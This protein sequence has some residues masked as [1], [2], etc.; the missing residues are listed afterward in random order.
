MNRSLLVKTYYLLFISLLIVGILLPSFSGYSQLSFTNVAAAKNLQISSVNKD[1]GFTF[2]DFNND[3]Y[4]DLLI[5]TNSTTS[6]SRLLYNNGAPNFTFTDV[7]SL[8]APALLLNINERSAIAGD[9]DNDGDIDFVRNTHSLIEVYKNSGAPNYTFTKSQF[10]NAAYFTG[11]GTQSGINSEGMGF[12]DFDGDGDLD[13]LIEDHEY[14]VDI[15]INNGTGIFSHYTT[16][17]APRGFGTTGTSGDYSLVADLNNDG[18]ID[19]LARREGSGNNNAQADIFMNNGN[20]TFS[21]NITTNLNASNSN[22]GGVAAGDF[23]GDGDLDYFWTDNGSTGS[24]NNCFLVEQTGVNSGVFAVTTVTV[25]GS[26]TSLPSAG[27]IDGVTIG[28]VNHDGKIDLFLTAN[29]GTS[30]LLI[31]TSA[32][33]GLFSFNHNNYGI[34][35]NADGEGCEFVDFD[36][37]GDL[38]L[39]INVNNG[40]NQLWINALN[41]NKYVNVIPLIDIGGGLTRPA[42]GATVILRNCLGE[43]ISPIMEVNGGSGHGTQLSTI[44]HFGLPAGAQTVYYAEVSFVRPNG[45]SRTVVTKQIYLG[46]LPD[47][48]IN[49]VNTDAS[50]PNM[51]YVLS[52]PGLIDFSAVKKGE[53]TKIQWQVNDNA[54]IEKYEVEYNRQSENFI[55]VHS[56]PDNNSEN[57]SFEHFIKNEGTLYYRLKIIHTDKSISYSKIVIINSGENNTDIQKTYPN[58]FSSYITTDIQLEQADKIFVQLID[59][60]GNTIKN[61]IVQ[62]QPGL[63]RV[64]LNELHKL[65]NG[66]YF[67]KIKTGNQ[68]VSK[69]VFKN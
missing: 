44:L 8:K 21:L 33:A 24:G 37:D 67:I 50:D 10:F 49:I 45:G 34:N 13:L 12:I 59:I 5:N 66:L 56:I 42:I 61:E 7:T 55:S 52:S 65:S 64:T 3:G 23:D 51:C 22:K 28:D 6:Y 41:D 14:G 35:V 17:A 2:A 69:K 1:G 63:N 54:G 48:T 39:Y 20:G 60:S 57:Y 36:N 47:Q 15:M 9:I 4:K 11:G 27:L 29:S 62:G 58:P 26:S 30:F 38:D 43:R 16:D 68:I 19:I 18:Y 46:L 40:N 53:I 25:T 31:N 32:G